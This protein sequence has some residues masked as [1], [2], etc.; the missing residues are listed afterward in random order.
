[1]AA[2]LSPDQSKAAL[3]ALDDEY[4]ALATYQV[5]LEK[6]GAVRPFSNI[7]KAEQRHIDA[8]AAVLK[9]SGQ[10]VPGNPYLSGEKPRPEAPATLKE[11]CAIGVQ[12]EIAN[13]ALYD[14]QLLPVAKG[15]AQLVTI[16]TSLRDASEK[17]HLP[18]FQRCAK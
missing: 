12:A 16:F 9:D 10:T 5:V 3:A 7:I 6:F 14:D 8:V 4:H 2:P 17:N 18:A 11:A 1:M 15:N 13:A